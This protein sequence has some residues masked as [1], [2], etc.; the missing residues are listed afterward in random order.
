VVW[1]TLILVG[2]FGCINQAARAVNPP[3]E[4]GGTLTCR[5]IVETCDSGCSTP[6][7]LHGCTNQGTT[8]AAPQHQALL[9]CGQSAG[10]TDQACM[11]TN[12]PTQIETC[13][14]PMEPAGEPEPPG[15][16]P[17]PAEEAAPGAA[18]P[19]G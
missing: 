3:P 12:C 16:D 6:F 17:P 4:G 1:R 13:M 8:E 19:P 5:E 7:C 11:E 15:D 14:G 18:P 10:C 9:D 2:L